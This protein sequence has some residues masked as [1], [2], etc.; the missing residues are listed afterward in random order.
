EIEADQP[1]EYTN[2]TLDLFFHLGFN[3]TLCDWLLDFLTGRPQSV[4]IG[5]LMSGR[6]TVNT[7][8]PQGCVLSPVL[9]S[10]FTYDCVASH[11]DN[12]FLKFADDATVNGLISGGDETAYR[13]RQEGSSAAV[14]PEETATAIIESILT[15]CITVWYGNSTESG[16]NGRED[17]PGA[18][19]LSAGHLPLQSPQESLQ[20]HQRPLPPPAHTLQSSALW[21]E[22]Q[23]HEEQD[24]QA[25]GQ[26]L[27]T[28][29]KTHQQTQSTN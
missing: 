24:L 5:S 1:C 10:L 29:R 19:A 23:E 18:A 13:S 12:T 6:I 22:V 7:G 3:S 26:F 20:H 17:H 11:K 2:K 27:S 8:T 14:L 21:Q 15:S 4:R 9:Y 16:E 25:E 28:S